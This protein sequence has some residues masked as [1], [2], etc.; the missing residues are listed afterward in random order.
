MNTPHILY[1]LGL[2]VQGVA[3]IMDHE[4]V[5][6]PNKICNWLLNSSRDHFGLHQGQNVRVTMEYEIPKGHILR[7]TLSID[8]VQRVLQW[9]RQKRCS[10]RKRDGPGMAKKKN[11]VIIKSK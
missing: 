8:M 2:L 1:E 11:D 6:R 7:H 5:P 9:E 10:S 3:Y 4:V